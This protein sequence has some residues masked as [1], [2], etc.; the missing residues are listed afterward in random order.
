MFTNWHK[1]TI[2]KILQ[3]FSVRDS[4]RGFSRLYSWQAVENVPVGI[5]ERDLAQVVFGE[6]FLRG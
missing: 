2:A 4:F 5:V 6:P 3:E 1:L